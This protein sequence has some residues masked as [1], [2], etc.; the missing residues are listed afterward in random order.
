[1]KLTCRLLLAGTALSIAGHASA[2]TAVERNLPPVPQPPKQS[3]EVQDAL[4]AEADTTPIGPA[5]KALVLLDQ[6]EALRD[7]A[8]L[9][10]GVHVSNVEAVDRARAKS[11]LKRFIGQPLS[12]QL[13]AQIQ[14]EVAR[15]SRAAG[16]PFVSL[17]AP[18]QEITTGVLQ[19][20]VT[21]FRLDGV[22]VRGVTPGEAVAIKR[23]L[24]LSVGAPVN[25]QDLQED[26]DWINRDPFTPVSA[27][28]SPGR[29]TG[30][31]TL[32]LI[33]QAPAPVRVYAGWSNTGASST[34]LDRFFIGTIFKLPGLTGAYGSYQ[35]TGS[36]D[37]WL[38]NGSDFYAKE[39]R[40]RAQ[41]GRLYI[42]TLPRQNIEFTFSDAL[43]NQQVNKDFSVRQRTTE[44]TL[45]YRFALSTFGLAS[46]S[47]DV[48]VGLESKQQH[49]VVYF[50]NQVALDGTANYWQ[51]LLGYSK[52]W[53][54][55]T[56]SLTFAAN[57]HVSPGD[58]SSRRSAQ[59]AAF[60]NGRTKDDRFSYGTL[61][62]TAQ[63]RLPWGLGYSGQL[64]LQ[65]S[66]S[67][68]P[69]PAQ[70]GLGGDGL[71]RGYTPDEGAFDT[72]ALSRNELRLPA[73]ALPQGTQGQMAPYVFLDA[74]WGHDNQKKVDT[75]LASAGLGGDY[76]LGSH[77]SLGGNSAWV[78][79]NGQQ[80]RVGDWRVQLRST[81]T[82]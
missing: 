46:T 10:P 13:I 50:G 60:T 6:G 23:N 19:L 41:G 12:R 32:N 35:L 21:E 63:K 1:M 66:R 78:L 18:E 31:T 58:P 74:G 70:L 54:S 24:R 57:L 69:L 59:L 16:R 42:P 76:R 25:S 34:G 26:I 72:G 40:Y 17:S 82:F 20:R 7:P 71:V 52:S 77:F 53:A 44:A 81:V 37:S 36:G 15:L 68:L 38:R 39:P 14:A 79:R 8:T 75:F 62:L 2:Q 33:S 11:A 48:V 29:E 30:R 43:T 47:G 65:M 22:N 80:T 28:F 61:D 4:P 9:T 64:T 45:G 27:Q 51:A 49:R 56:G 73:I 55:N 67:A 5:L 3:V